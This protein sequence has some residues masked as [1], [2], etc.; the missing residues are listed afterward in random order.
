MDNYDLINGKLYKKCKSY[1]IR[2]PKTL[3]CVNINKNIGKKLVNNEND[4][5]CPI[6]KIYNPITKRCISIK[7]KLG[8]NLLG[9]SKKQPLNQTQTKVNIKSNQEKILQLIRTLKNELTNTSDLSLKSHLYK[10]H[11]YV[12]QLTPIIESK[13]S[14][15]S[16]S[17]SIKKVDSFLSDNIIEFSINDRITFHN[18]LLYLL[19]LI[20]TSQKN[21]CM[22]FLKY[23]KNKNPI[24]IINDNII[25]K[26]KIGND[27][28]DSIIYIS[29]IYDN[30][31]NKTLKYASKLVL[32]NKV[33]HNEL[34]Y[35]SILSNAVIQSHCPHFPILYANLEC[36]TFK[37]TQSNVTNLSN[38]PRIIQLNPNNSF[39]LLL[40]ELANGNLKS[41]TLDKSNSS[42]IINA[43]IQCILCLLFFYKETKSFYNNINSLNFIYHILNINQSTTY[44]YYNIFNFNFYL[45]N[46]G[47]LW[48]LWNFKKPIKF[49]DANSNNIYINHD[50]KLL[51]AIFNNPSIYKLLNQY[52]I[53]IISSLYQL[54]NLNN[55]IYSPINL[56]NFIKKIINFIKKNK[57]I[58]TTAPLPQQLIN[59]SPFSIRMSNFI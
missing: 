46:Q 3:R 22:R 2:N 18:K 15:K 41:F 58:I 5:D 35:L 28:I 40:T 26:N 54:V 36:S 38:Y 55:D 23:D 8:R 34:Y 32:H 9:L 14:S 10:S 4:K 16:S 12:P 30:S 27:N 33:F 6:G 17:I 53:N 56:T 52:D 50:I 20:S 45:S 59:S 47:F 44:F 29:H 39:S 48:V 51:L 25:L 1:Q 11:K 42:K 57:L 7:S 19:N 31:T 37:S 21:Y 49:I 43:L 13:S 24:Y